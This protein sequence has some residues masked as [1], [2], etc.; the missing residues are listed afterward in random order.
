MINYILQVVL[1]QVFFLAIYDFFLSKETF[2]TKNRWYLVSTPMLSFLIP[3]IKIPTFQK[4]VPE[5]FIVNLPEIFLSPEKAIQKTITETIFYETVNYVTILFWMGVAFFTILFVIKLVKI[6]SLIKKYEVVKQP[7]F[8]LVLIPNQTQAFSF[9]NY[10]FLGKN[11]EESKRN[12]II[13]HE[14]VHSKQKHS[15]DLL[16]F[17]FLKIVMWF[18]P[19]I[20]FYQQRITLVHEYIS[21]AIV[22]KSET[23]ESYINNLL[24]NFFQ[25]ENIAFVNQFYKKSLIKKRIIMMTKTQSKKMNQLKYLVLI[26]VLMSMLFYVSCSETASKEEVLESKKAK[27]TLYIN[28][29]GKIKETTGKEITF[30]DVYLGFGKGF[31]YPNGKELSIDDLNEGEK[32]EFLE[33]KESSE[34]GED[35]F[36]KTRIFQYNKGRKVIVFSPLDENITETLETEEIS[37]MKIEKAPTFPG[38]ET[39]DKDCFSLNVQKHFSKN[40]NADLPKT[41]GLEAGRKRIFIGFKIDKEG[42]IVDVK[43]RAPHEKLEQEVLR[44]MNTLPKVVPGEHQG[45]TIAVKYSIPFT[46]VID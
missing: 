30:L 28:N 9:F 40:F 35:F 16:L 14:L 5:E 7:D 45:K 39:G 32:K 10:V 4:A 17:E 36:L 6:I 23:K 37:F 11:I 24:S 26:P 13:Q 3:F 1:F 25:V 15:L 18:N 8:T 38:C 46:L 27:Q 34:S 12:K 43:A 2:F 22:A 33:F 29:N 20:Y 31:E 44:V 41:L 42:N 19:M 21:D